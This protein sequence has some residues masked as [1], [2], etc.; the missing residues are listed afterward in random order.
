[1]AAPVV[2]KPWRQM[3]PW[4]LFG[5]AAVALLVSLVAPW[6]S[7]VPAERTP[8]RLQVPLPSDQFLYTT[9]GTAAVLS[10]DGK[11][12]AYVAGSRESRQ[13]YVRALDQLEAT[14]L[15][16]TE[17][18]HGPFF[19]PDGQWVGFT[20]GFTGE[21]K[22]KKISVSGGAPLTLCDTAGTNGASWGPDDTIIFNRA[23][24]STGLSQVP[25]AGGTPQEIT[26]PDTENREEHRY[27]QFLPGGRWV[28]FSVGRRG[29]FSEANIEVLSLET[30]ER[31]VLHRGGYNVHYLPT[32]HLIFMHET[33]LFA[34]PFDL[35]RLE[36]TGSPVPVLESVR[37]APRSGDA[38]FAF[39]Q[40]GMLV[41]LPGGEEFQRR[42]VWVDREGNEEA[43]PGEPR[44]YQH[45]R[46]SPDGSRL[47]VVIEEREISSVRIYDLIRMASTPIAAGRF[48]GTPLWTPNGRRVVFRDNG[49]LFWKAAD[50]TGQVEQLT[51]SQN[52]QRA[53]SFSPDG[54]KLVFS[55]QRDLHVL[56]MAGERSPQSLLQT[57]FS[58]E[59]AVISPDGR[60]IAYVSNETGQR[61]VYV[62]PFPNVEEGRWPIST[63][64]GA[65]PVWAPD[66]SELFYR[67]GEA[68][69]AV[70]VKPEP[71]FT[72]GSPR[73]LFTG[74]YLSSGPAQR[75]QQYD[76]S[77]D[78]QRFLML[79]EG[80]APTQL[81]V[82][83]N[84][85]EELK[86]LVPTGE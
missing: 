36:L 39:S 63:E 54:K 13:L 76:V 66:G 48:T 80:S 27:P 52:F 3:I 16:G 7:T 60:W 57:P 81:I 45:P 78:G 69:M 75:A 79:K 58:E 17:G 4:V 25:A 24:S 55:E 64:G 47:A 34:A 21:R 84:W 53:D 1:M 8:V 71:T 67:S 2:A 38:Q 19:S 65:E 10:P 23:G 6:R 18:A 5:L 28:V 82:V 9:G 35:G 29:A 14:P 32:G 20:A 15:P 85:F 49:G 51:A 59:H 61:E 44:V 41:Y 62:R 30:G 11:Q 33:T 42:V 86:R 68:M 77:P 50:G 37:S 22:L 40:S 43:L 83:Q 31:K 74:S 26:V 46:L 72:V 73:L 12:L 56:S 70:R